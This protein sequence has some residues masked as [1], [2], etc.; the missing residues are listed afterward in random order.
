MCPMLR[1]TTTYVC[2]MLPSVYAVSV[3]CRVS[4]HCME[5]YSFILSS[6]D[7]GGQGDVTARRARTVALDRWHPARTLSYR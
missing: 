6:V 1:V 4:A 3:D 7:M 5:E 2:S